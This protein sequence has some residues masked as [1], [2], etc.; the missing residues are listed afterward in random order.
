MLGQSS[1]RIPAL[2]LGFAAVLFFLQLD[3]P[4]C[5]K[6]HLAYLEVEASTFPLPRK[7]EAGVGTGAADFFLI[8]SV[9]FLFVIFF[10]CPDSLLWV[11]FAL[12]GMVSTLLSSFT[13]GV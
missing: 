7:T 5:V 4:V 13:H 8:Y 1:C 10:S 2:E 12:L 6:D 11:S 9:I 3:L